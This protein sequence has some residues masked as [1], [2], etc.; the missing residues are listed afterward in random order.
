MGWEGIGDLIGTIAK[1]W[2]PEKVK[3]RARSKLLKLVEEENGLLKKDCTDKI[4]TRLMRVR[5]DIR[6]LQTYLANN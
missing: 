2:T 1:W 3:A 6:R 4:A 5:R